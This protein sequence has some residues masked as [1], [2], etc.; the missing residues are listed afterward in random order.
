MVRIFILLSFFFI[1]HLSNAQSPLYHEERDILY[2]EGA[3]PYSQEKCRLDL[4][5]PKDTRDFVT[6]LWLHGGGLTGGKREIPEAL[7]GKG[8][9][10]VALGYRFAPQ[11]TVDDIL[12]DVVEAVKWVYTHIERYGG[13]KKKIVLGGYSAGGY[14]ALMLGLNKN[15][16]ESVGI[17]VDD[18]LGIVSFSGQAITHFTAR[19]SLGMPETQPLV[20]QLAP[21]YWV[22][23]DAP[24][25]MLITGD[26]DMEMLGRYEENAY[27]KRMLQLVGHPD[28]ELFELD[29]YDHGMTYPAFPLLLKKIDRW[30][31]KERND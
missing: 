29:G 4:Y 25:I 27:L 30:S 15:Y 21:L 5:F 1:T 16:L 24:S 7:K 18:M 17:R 9:G 26:R 6:V 13:D 23:K 12:T 2:K 8:I 28:V 3:D 11:V 31:R 14:L 22:R 20:D 10:V 19:K